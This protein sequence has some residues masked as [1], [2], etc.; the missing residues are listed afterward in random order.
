MSRADPTPSL[1]DAT[2]LP[3]HP[4]LS[5]YRSVTN[6]WH[7][8]TVHVAARELL[9]ML[10]QEGQRRARRGRLQGPVEGVSPAGGPNLTQATDLWGRDR[11][12]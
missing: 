10:A 4:S 9:A 5:D 1:P 11:P 3:Q 2:D 12:C 8:D 7:K 6:T